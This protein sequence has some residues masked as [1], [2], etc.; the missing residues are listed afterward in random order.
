MIIV[1]EIGLPTEMDMKPTSKHYNKELQMKVTQNTRTHF[2]I[3]IKV[4]IPRLVRAVIKRQVLEG[5][6]WSPMIYHFSCNHLEELPAA[7]I[8]IIKE[9]KRLLIGE[10]EVSRLGRSNRCYLFLVE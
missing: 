2:L 4:F 1:G 10:I 6:F 3:P 8:Y 7:F 5:I 9:S